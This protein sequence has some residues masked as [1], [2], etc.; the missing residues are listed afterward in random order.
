MLFS[1]DP[2]SNIKEENSSLKQ[3]KSSMLSCVKLVVMD[4]G[5]ADSA[6]WGLSAMSI[7]LLRI[8]G[9]EIRLG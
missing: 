7:K 1:S 6:N 4:N 5:I 3:L 9:R 8:Y 2:E